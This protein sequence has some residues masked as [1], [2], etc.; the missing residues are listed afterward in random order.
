[1]IMLI[2]SLAGYTTRGPVYDG[3]MDGA[4]IVTR[5]TTPFF[6]A[7]RVLLAKGAAPDMPLVMRHADAHHDA[8][9][10]T[11][12]KA[13]GLSV[14]DSGGKPAFRT[15]EPDARFRPTSGSPMGFGANKRIAR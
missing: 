11:V 14:E 7:A 5:S 2:I 3:M 8:L 15:Y 9:R 1:M 12:G 4:T 6:D 10:S 13:A